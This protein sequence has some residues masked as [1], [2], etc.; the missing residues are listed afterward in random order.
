L[1]ACL[2]FA[3]EV[4]L[5]T[6]VDRSLWMWPVLGLGY[7]GLAALLLELLQRYRVYELFGGLVLAGTYGLLASALLNPAVAFAGLPISL[8][9]RVMGAQTAAGALGLALCLGLVGGV[10]R[11]RLWIGA[12][13]V[14]AFWGVWVRG[15]PAVLGTAPETAA[16]PLMLMWGGVAGAVMLA[17]TVAV[18]RYALA[19]ADALNLTRA[20]WAVVGVVLALVTAVR[21]VQGHITR[22]VLSYVVVLVF[23]CVMILWFQQARENT[24]LFI[25]RTPP[26][27]SPVVEMVVALVLFLG[28]GA[29]T[30]QL[31]PSPALLGIISVA[32]GG[33]GLS[34]LPAVCV[35][36]GVRAYRHT[37]RTGKSL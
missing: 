25:G 26:R 22:D 5:W 21:G 13:A 9:T 29:L 35:V 7:V 8:V 32:F 10:R 20:T 1:A 11:N 18:G 3:S 36:L 34:W 4:V 19:D 15:T 23:F 12:A 33:F 2:F 16:L 24:T 14:G 31:P 28:V 27:P 37:S 17:L 6:D 30:Y